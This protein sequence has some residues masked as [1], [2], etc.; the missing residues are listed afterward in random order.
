MKLG[1]RGLK[2]PME[3]GISWRKFTTK[4]SWLKKITSSLFR[5]C[6]FCSNP[7]T[8]IFVFAAFPHKN[9]AC[10]FT[11]TY[12]FQCVLCRWYAACIFLR[13]IVQHE[14]F[15]TAYLTDHLFSFIDS[16]AVFAEDA[17]F[18]SAFSVV[19]VRS[20][21]WVSSWKRRRLR[22]YSHLIP[23]FFNLSRLGSK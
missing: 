4:L 20:D 21:K 11:T 8:S 16:T 19:L 2:N 14:T 10:V 9:L 22:L 17:A 7:N 1:C 13:S 12:R 15:K 3:S 6:N 23:I 5:R 18:L